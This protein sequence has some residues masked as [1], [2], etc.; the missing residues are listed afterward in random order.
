MVFCGACNRSAPTDVNSSSPSSSS[1]TQTSSAVK[2]YPFKGKIVSVDTKAG[3]ANID[4]ED[5]PG[6]MGA[7]TMLYQI[8]PVSDLQK[9]HAGDSISGDLV[10]DNSGDVEKYWLEKV[11]IAPATSP[12]P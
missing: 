12:K 11:T 5:I 1:S 9:L 3:N 2:H 4:G 10:V 6:F 7:M 8:R